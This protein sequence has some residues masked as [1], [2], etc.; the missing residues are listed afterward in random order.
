MQKQWG[1]SMNRNLCITAIICVVLLAGCS[2]ASEKPGPQ[3]QGYSYTDN[4][5]GHNGQAAGPVRQMGNTVGLATT[6]WPGSDSNTGNP[7]I[8]LLHVK[9]PVQAGDKGS[10]S[11]AGKPDTVYTVKATYNSS[12]GALTS[13]A[14]G[15]SGIDG[16]VSWVWN[17]KRDTLPGTYQLI[18]SGGGKELRSSYTVTR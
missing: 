3:Q 1:A 10:L 4:A 18:I 11:I 2:S 6:G 14:S 5:S 8:T 9:S 17:V 16:R 15:Y 13:T 12:A 7:G